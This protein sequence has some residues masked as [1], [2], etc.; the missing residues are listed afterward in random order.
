MEDFFDS[1]FFIG[2]R[3]RLKELTGS[4]LIVLAAHGT[5]QRSSDETFEFRQDSGFWYLTGIDEPDYILVINGTST[6]LIEP[7]R[8]EHRDLW[9]GAIDKRAFKQ[10]S[11]IEEVEEYHDGWIRLDK[12]IKKYKKVHTFAPAEVYFEQFGFYAN[13]ARKM[14]LD[15]LMKH[16]KLEIVDIR[17]QVAVLRQL[18]QEPEIRAIRTAVKITADSLRLVKKNLSR[19]KSEHE[20]EADLT[21]DFILARA[22]GHAY[23]P[24]IAGGAGAATIHYRSNN[25][26]LPENG[27]LLIDAGAEVSHYSADI[28]RTFAVGKPSKRQIDAFDAAMHVYDYAISQL[29]PGILPR[30]YEKGVDAC[31]AKQLKKLK[32]IND[33]TDKKALRKYYPHLASH[34]LG[35]DTHD[36]AD[37]ERPLEPGMVLTLEPGIYIQSEGIGIRIEDDL[38]ITEKGVEVLSASLPATLL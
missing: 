6:F 10:R 23:R 9:D 1:T 25:K 11:G 22:D 34:F 31:M 37:Y 20:I 19:Y 7:K 4:E 12:L 21:R 8:A 27:L 16:R 15:A 30:E 26:L 2:N 17:K 3:D 29:K 14:L 18:K 28:T 24:V 36:A 5:L 33:V 13:P 35:L 32:L 38:L